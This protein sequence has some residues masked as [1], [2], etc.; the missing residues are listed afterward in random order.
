MAATLDL[1]QKA[2]DQCTHQMN[3]FIAGSSSNKTLQ[4]ELHQCTQHLQQL[5]LDL[6]AFKS[7]Q[8]NSMKA[9]A[10]VQTILSPSSNVAETPV[11]NPRLRRLHSTLQYGLGDSEF[12]PSNEFATTTVEGRG[13]FLGNSPLKSSSLAL[14]V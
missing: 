3:T 9:N 5:T 11:V 2:T 14:V 10:S 12:N 1:I 4:I 6:E 13:R 8:Q 7:P